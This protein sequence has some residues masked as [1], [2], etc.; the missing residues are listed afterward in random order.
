MQRHLR[1]QTIRAISLGIPGSNYKNLQCKHVI[2]QAGLTEFR[3]PH[4]GKLC[5]YI[6]PHRFLQSICYSQGTASK[7]LESF[8]PKILSTWMLM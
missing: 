8:V 6:L 1:N 7:A 2:S 3:M 4:Q 5:V